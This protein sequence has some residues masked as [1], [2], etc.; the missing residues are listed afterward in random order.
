MPAVGR[1]HLSAA[2]ITIHK[3]AI[4]AQWRAHSASGCLGIDHSAVSVTNTAKSTAFYQRLGLSRS[5]SSANVGPEQTRLDGVPDA[6]VE[7]TTLAP[8]QSTPHVELL[9]YRGNFDRNVEQRTNDVTAARLVFT[10]E[11]RIEFDQLV[12]QNAASLLP[13]DEKYEPT[14]RRALLR[15]PDG[16]LICVETEG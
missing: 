13:D 11:S 8:T 1:I 7:V 9:C 3:N 15:D 5:G 14:K 6:V 10:A 12:A 2:M 16:H 4:P